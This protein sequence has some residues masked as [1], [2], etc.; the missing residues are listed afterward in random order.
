MKTRREA[1]AFLRGITLAVALNLAPAVTLWAD[2][3]TASVP[4]PRSMA[5]AQSAYGHLPLSFE[6]I[7]GS[8]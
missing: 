2:P 8:A 4:P 6:A 1:V 7:R 3:P 5:A